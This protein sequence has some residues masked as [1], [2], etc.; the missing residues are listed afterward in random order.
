MLERSPDHREFS[1]LSIDVLKSNY[2]SSGNGD[3]VDFKLETKKKENWANDEYLRVEL[4]AE[5][6]HPRAFEVAVD[7]QLGLAGGVGAG[8]VVD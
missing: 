7:E 6:G 1:A 3:I 8:P 2:R 4:G 5:G